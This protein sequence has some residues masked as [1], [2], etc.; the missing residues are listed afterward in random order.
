M[1]VEGGGEEGEAGAGKKV[2]CQNL[3]NDNDKTH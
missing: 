1:C 2:I 3:D